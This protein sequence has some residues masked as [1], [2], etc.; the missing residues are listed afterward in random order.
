MAWGTPTSLGSAANSVG[1][2]VV[3]T[4]TASS[5][6]GALIVIAVNE[7]T[8]LLTGSSVADSAGN[9][10]TL[11]TAQLAGGTGGR[12]GRFF[13]CPNALALSSGGTITYT[14]SVSG[15]NC[16]AQA[17][18]V[19]GEDSNP[20][21]SAVTAGGGTATTTPSVTSGT[22][23]TAGEMFFA[24]AGAASTTWTNDTTNGWTNIF[25]VN[26]SSASLIVS[27]QIVPT[28]TTK[29]WAPTDANNQNNFVI[30]IG[31]KVF[32]FV[33]SEQWTGPRV[34]IS[35]IGY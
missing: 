5:P 32:L 17:T 22:P 21:D 20:L 7:N 16:Q 33:P 23:T 28:I 12:S 30:V 10:Y 26:A 15:T 6:A 18:S 35:V 2:T 24:L 31:F 8:A 14:R 9:T 19:T 3:I 4:T 13:Y 1:A 29:T 27:Y 11:A 25:N 34:I